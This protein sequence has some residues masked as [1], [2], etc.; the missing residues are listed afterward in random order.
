[1]ATIKDDNGYISTL[2]W[3]SIFM[4][5]ARRLRAENPPA[6]A[7]QLIHVASIEAMESQADELGEQL[8]EYEKQ[9]DE[10]KIQSEIYKTGNAPKGQR[11]G[12]GRDADDEK[13]G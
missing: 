3:Y 9:V 1:M 6:I 7:V 10:G 11:G 4:R 12:M 8:D 5:E 2:R 13:T